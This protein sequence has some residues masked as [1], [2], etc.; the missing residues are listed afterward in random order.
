[1]KVKTPRWTTE[2]FK[3]AAQAGCFHDMKVEL[4]GGR[5]V[6]MTESP[7]HRTTVENI[8]ERFAE[9]FAKEH[10]YVARESSVEFD[11][12]T[13]L[14]DIAVCRGPRKPTY[15][16]RAPRPGDIA[17]L[18]EVSHSTYRYD[19]RVKL[20]RYAK[21]GVPLVWIVNLESRTIEV[22]SE[23]RGNRYLS[24][25]VFAEGEWVRLR[26]GE[27]PNL[28]EASIEVAEVLS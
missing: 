20:P 18:V 26:T 2:R 3:L 23:P 24:R 12:W 28:I 13:P 7:E 6:E 21:A 4:V 25:K 11:D 22:F 27:Q 19:R 8:V 1:V 15:T 16:H 14:P 5:L 17:L 10:W 9:V